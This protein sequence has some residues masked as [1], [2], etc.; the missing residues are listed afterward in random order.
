M[1]C[2]PV[3][4]ESDYPELERAMRPR[5][6]AT[7]VEWGEIVDEWERS[8]R[9]A[10]IAYISIR[11]VEFITYMTNAGRELDIQALLDFAAFNPWH[12]PD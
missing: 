1:F 12:D 7:F 6:P 10:G 4:A 9:W 3:I 2:L 11:P 8:P 5:I